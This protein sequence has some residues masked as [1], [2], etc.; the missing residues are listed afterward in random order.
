[1]TIQHSMARAV[2]ALT[3]TLWLGTAHAVTGI[4]PG[5]NLNFKVLRDGDEVGTHTLRFARDGDAT[6]VEVETHVN[7]TLPF[8]GVSVYHFD[9]EGAETWRD[10]AL[11]AL[12]SRT[13]DDGKDH[14]LRVTRSGDRLEVRS[15][16]GEHHS[17]GALLPA[18]LWNPDLVRHRVLLNTLDG[19]E[20]PVAVVDEG[21]EAVDVRGTTVRARHYRLTGGLDRELWYDADGVLVKV[22]FAAKDDSRID[23]VL[24]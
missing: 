14:E 7:V 17:S 4:P 1:M 6:R 19:R 10:G 18:S 24:P 11:V 12:S 23:Y 8:I 15:N 16:T 5:G 21:E 2:L 3:A 9:H 22:S 13:D 20:M